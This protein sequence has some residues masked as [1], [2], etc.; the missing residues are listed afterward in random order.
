VTEERDLAKE[1]LA[2][3]K[4]DMR[5]ADIY[6][7]LTSILASTLIPFPFEGASV[8]MMKRRHVAS[9]CG[10]RSALPNPNPNPNCIVLRLEVRSDQPVG[11]SSLMPSILGLALALILALTL[12]LA[13]IR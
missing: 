2:E 11:G 6:L 12:A 5:L 8:H 1:A 3:A 13:L 9:F 4:D 10:S 7:T